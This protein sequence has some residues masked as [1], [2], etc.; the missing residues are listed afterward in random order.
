MLLSI[1]E[2][3]EGVGQHAQAGLVLHAGQT[4]LQDSREL[5]TLLNILPGDAAQYADLGEG[6]AFGTN[7][8]LGT[9]GKGGGGHAVPR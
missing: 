5:G 6:G 1:G 9:A 3:I 7:E 4:V 2:A 8:D